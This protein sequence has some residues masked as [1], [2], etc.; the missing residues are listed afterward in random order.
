MDSFT[1]ASGTQGVTDI[2]VC[3]TA[4]T[5]HAQAITMTI[6]AVNLINRLY[7]SVK[8]CIRDGTLTRSVQAICS[9]Q[10]A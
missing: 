7:I 9:E 2:C 5:E 10:F 4:N 6:T 1:N 8:Y 3:Q